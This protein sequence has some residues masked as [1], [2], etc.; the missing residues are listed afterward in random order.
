MFKMLMVAVLC[1][2]LLC[3]PLSITAVMNTAFL[4]HGFFC[5]ILS[6]IVQFVY[7]FLYIWCVVV[8][9]ASCLPYS[10]AFLD[11]TIVFLHSPP[12]VHAGRS[13]CHRNS[14]LL[15]GVTYNYATHGRFSFFVVMVF[16]VLC[17]GMIFL[18]C[19]FEGY[20][21]SW[22]PAPKYSMWAFIIW[23]IDCSILHST[24]I[25]KKNITWNI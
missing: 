17:T 21:G 24:L 14:Q 7:V 6:Y 3:A 20:Y 13:R 4:E 5:D 10:N 19:H 23:T 2:D 22:E 8:F 1:T 12:Y 9:I 25:L 18:P 11:S 16:Y 15:S